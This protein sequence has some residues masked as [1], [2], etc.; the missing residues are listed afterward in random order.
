[1]HGPEALLGD[2]SECDPPGVVETAVLKTQVVRA[3]NDRHTP[4]PDHGRSDGRHTARSSIRSS[5]SDPSEISPPFG[6]HQ[7]LQV[8]HDSKP[9]N[10]DLSEA[11]DTSSISLIR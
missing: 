5:A 6:F 4:I 11:Q 8:A 9:E 7:A 3:P 10:Q 1:M 2:V